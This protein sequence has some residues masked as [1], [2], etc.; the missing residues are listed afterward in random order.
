MSPPG[1]GRRAAAEGVGTFLLVCFGPG[2]AVVGEWNPG[3]IPAGGV[4]VAFLLTVAILVL[5]LAP[6]SGGHINPAVTLVLAATRRFPLV[7][8]LPYTVAQLIG[9]TAGGFA[10]SVLFPGHIAAATTT[11]VFG[12][13]G[14][15][16]VE[17]LLSCVLM[18]VILRAS[19]L[20][21]SN[22]VGAALAIGIAV[23]LDALV[24]GPLTGASMN[25]ARTFGP[26]LVASQWSLHW[27]YWVGPV[28]GMLLAGGLHHFLKGSVDVRQ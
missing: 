6:I 7:E 11:S 21:G 26:A 28:G 19:A 17:G 3:A 16:A 5:I 14:T 27:A 18:L 2:A 8:V 13:L 20:P 4:A 10:L 23:G 22:A 15:V 1:L 25:P 12:A 24:G 9:A